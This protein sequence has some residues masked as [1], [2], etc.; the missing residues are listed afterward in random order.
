LRSIDTR[1]GTR[2]LTKTRSFSLS[3]SPSLPLSPLIPRISLISFNNRAQRG[4]CRLEQ[5]IS[6]IFPVAPTN[7]TKP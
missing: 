2:A 6:H 1:D 5:R 4:K 3:L 7:V